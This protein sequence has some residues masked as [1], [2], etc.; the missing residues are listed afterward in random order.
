VSPIAFLAD[1]SESPVET[2]ERTQTE[3]L[4]AEGLAKALENLDE[5]SRR[6]IRARWLNES[7]PEDPHE[8][9]DEFGVSAERIRQI[10]A[11]AM[12]KMKK[13][14]IARELRLGVQRGSAGRSSHG[15]RA[16]TG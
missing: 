10:E 3:N 7:D 8:L 4:E 14:R 12:Q 11:K 2:L 6:I 1:S 9:A 15:L 13:Q 16:L 5:R